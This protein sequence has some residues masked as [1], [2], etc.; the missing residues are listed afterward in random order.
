MLAYKIDEVIE[1]SKANPGFEFNT[2]TRIEMR[3]IKVNEQ[4]KREG[5]KF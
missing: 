5:L 4:R 1:M 2:N 3:P